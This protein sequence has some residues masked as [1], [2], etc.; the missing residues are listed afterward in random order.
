M[1]T[2][3]IPNDHSRETL[4]AHD[5]VSIGIACNAFTLIDRKGILDQLLTQGSYDSKAASPA[6]KAALLSLRLA[7]ALIQEN[8]KFYLTNLGHQLAQARGLITM[9]FEGY[10][11]LMAQQKDNLASP[12]KYINGAAIALASIQFGKEHIDPLV[13]ETIHNLKPRRTICDLGCGT[14]DRLVK[15]CQT[16]QV[17][18]LGLDNH[19]EALKLFKN[20]PLISIE[21][22][23]VSHLKGVWE[24]VE[25]LMQSFMAHDIA[26]DDDCIAMLKSYTQ[27]FPNFKYLIIVDIVAP[28]D[29]SSSHMPGFDYIHGLQGIETRKYNH[30]IS[31]F[32]KAGYQIVQEHHT[33][34]P[35]TYL[36]LLR[37]IP[38]RR[39]KH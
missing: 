14:A 4:T 1:R 38:N 26:V 15:V 6:I 3:F 9:L 17:P 5:F 16:L 34:M 2:K 12:S 30:M 27:H 24:D 33:G 11:R 39:T 28:E 22:A 37:Y 10:G 13:V 31:L 36:W 8:S 23:D 7:N 18:G 19:P 25:I 20:H 29:D 21:Q 32:E 35:N